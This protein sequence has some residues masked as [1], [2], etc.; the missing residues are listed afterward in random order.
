MIKSYK[1]AHKKEDIIVNELNI[2]SADRSRKDISNWRTALIGAESVYYP[3]RS[4]LYDLYEDVVLD[5]HLSGVIA[6]R[7]DA[8][9]NKEIC[10]EAG[11][12]KNQAIEELVH[13]LSFRDIM[14]TIMETQLWGI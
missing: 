14:R 7:M 1:T 13:S 4:R 10:F 6:K 5:G 8:V 2:R 9:L 12:K 3:N 11:G